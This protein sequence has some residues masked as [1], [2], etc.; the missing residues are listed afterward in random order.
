MA[1]NI[2]ALAGQGIKLGNAV[3]FIAEEFDADG[4]FIIIS[5]VDIHN[6]AVNAEL[7]ADKVHIVAFILQLDQAAAELVP[8]HLH[9]GAQADDHAAVIDRVAQ[10]I[11][12]GN[13][14]HNDNIAPPDSAAVAEWRRRSI[15][16]L[17]ALSF[18]I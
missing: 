16:S 4:V 18:S 1:H 14:R 7:I 9:T 2:F 15:S 10:G 3:D 6:I 5:K 11:N 8:L 13:R 17:M 12:A